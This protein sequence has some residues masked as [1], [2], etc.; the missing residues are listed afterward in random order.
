MLYEL[1]EKIEMV[2]LFGE[3]GRNVEEAILAY[4]RRFPDKNT[5]SRKTFFRVI[6]QLKETGNVQSRPK[7]RRRTTTDE[8]NETAVLAAISYDPHVSSR[9]LEA[10]SGISRRSILRITKRNKLHPYHISLHQELH[11]DDFVNRTA[12][13]NWAQGKIREDPNFFLAVLFSDESSFTNHG[14]VNR[15]NMHYWATENPHWIRQVERQ[16]PWSLNVWGGILGVQVV[17]PFLVE[18]ALTGQKYRDFLTNTL[19]L[20]LE[21]VSLELRQRMWLQHDGCPAHY[22]RLARAI[23]DESYQDRW[24]GRGGPVP[25]PPRSPDLTSP[26]F[27]LWG[28][29]KEKVYKEVPTTADD[30]RLRIRHA[31]AG[32]NAGVLLQ[33]HRSFTE[34][35]RKCIEVE[36]HHFEHLLR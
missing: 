31:F 3:T 8:L 12:F 23:L 28:Y 10:D 9:V 18:G 35:V 25:W 34:R 1:S 24:I 36:G 17:G 20:L 11:G 13:C 22:S 2:L 7:T 16:R 27:F 19:P 33:V 5:P 14:N 4:A 30:M 21:D 26:D 32:I 29:V 6:K 15:H